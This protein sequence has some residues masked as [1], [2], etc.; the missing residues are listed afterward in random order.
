MS[1]GHFSPIDPFCPKRFGGVTGADGLVELRAAP[2]EGRAV[3]S[4]TAAGYFAVGMHAVDD[5]L[6]RA[7][8]R[9]SFLP[10]EAVVVELYA[11]PAAVV[12]VVVPA[13]HRGLVGIAVERDERPCPIRAREFRVYVSA[14]GMARLSGPG[15]L[16]RPECVD[17]RLRY[18]DGASLEASPG[19][20]AVGAWRLDEDD[21]EL[22]YFVGTRQEYDAGFHLL[23][24]P[25]G[26]G[27][28]VFDRESARARLRMR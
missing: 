10:R 28:W 11:E 9:D 5:E 20:G 25:T 1:L 26:E 24:R 19:D 7:G 2:Y 16:Q 8:K 3:V 17:Y 21:E 14:S 12:D 13:G 23:H 4:A 18:A 6:I 15:L 27:G 22:F